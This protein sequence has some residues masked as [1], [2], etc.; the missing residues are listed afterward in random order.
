MVQIKLS[1]EAHFRLRV[2]TARAGVRS[3][4]EYLESAL[5]E[6]IVNDD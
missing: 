5:P 2:A 1:E 3:Y 4:S 6:V